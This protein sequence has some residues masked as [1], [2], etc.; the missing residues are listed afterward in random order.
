MK[1]IIIKTRK[2]IEEQDT[3]NPDYQNRHYT[4]YMDARKEAGLSSDMSTEDNF[5]KYLCEDIDLGF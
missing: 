3:V 4:R 2:E 1:D 5:I